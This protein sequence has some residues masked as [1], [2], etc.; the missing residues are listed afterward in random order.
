MKE[1]SRA[2]WTGQRIGF[3]VEGRRIRKVSQVWELSNLESPG[4]I[5]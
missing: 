3:E 1:R 2:N 4:V 5:C